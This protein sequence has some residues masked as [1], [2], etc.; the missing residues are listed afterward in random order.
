VRFW[1]TEPSPQPRTSLTREAGFAPAR[2]RRKAKN[3]SK[4]QSILAVSLHDDAFAAGVG[5][6]QL[7]GA[8]RAIGEIHDLL[9]ELV[10][11]SQATE[12]TERLR[13]ILLLH[14]GA[15]GSFC[16]SEAGGGEPQRLRI[17]CEQARGLLGR[18]TKLKTQL[19]GGLRQ[20]RGRPCQQQSK[21]RDW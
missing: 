5:D 12:S 8:F 7:R 19:D 11:S 14:L 2:P 1:A 21:E 9:A 15:W 13:N 4:R 10:V 18:V 6:G 16:G 3:R 17:E 20:L